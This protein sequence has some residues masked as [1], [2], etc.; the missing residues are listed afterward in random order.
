M[1]GFSVWFSSALY[2]IL[3]RA[4]IY[5]YSRSAARV[6]FWH[7]LS[8]HSVRTELLVVS[9][10]GMLEILNLRRKYNSTDCDKAP[11]FSFDLEHDSWGQRS[12]GYFGN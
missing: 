6:A 8:V 11:I 10:N 3:Y 1:V 4:F 7:P 9:S 12:L 2:N 5:L